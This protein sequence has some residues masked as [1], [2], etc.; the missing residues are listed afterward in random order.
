MSSTFAGRTDKECPCRKNN[1]IIQTDTQ[2]PCDWRNIPAMQTEPNMK[3]MDEAA[4]TAIVAVSLDSGELS[5]AV[6][7]LSEAGRETLLAYVLCGFAEKAVEMQGETVAELS[8]CQPGEIAGWILASVE[9]PL[10][11]VSASDVNRYLA[12][13]RE[14]DWGLGAEAEYSGEAS[15]VAGNYH[16]K[17]KES[18]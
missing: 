15:C 17:P 2:C 7:A 18:K 11:G 5:S 1:T 10:C 4:E 14:R 6:E 16:L 12:D 3:R 9:N 8:R 13:L